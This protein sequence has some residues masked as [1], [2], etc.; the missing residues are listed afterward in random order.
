MASWAVVGTWGRAGPTDGGTV[1]GRRKMCAGANGGDE[2]EADE[3]GWEGG[4]G[5][6]TKDVMVG[7]FR[8]SRPRHHEHRH[9]DGHRHP[10]PC[11]PMHAAATRST[12]TRPSEKWTQGS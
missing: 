1:K 9:A 6:R 8:S 7:L 5:G 2:M 12:A 10:S 3:C 11:P 4:G